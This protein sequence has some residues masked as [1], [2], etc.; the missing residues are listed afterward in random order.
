MFETVARSF[1]WLWSGSIELHQYSSSVYV[2][3]GLIV[4]VYTGHAK[5]STGRALSRMGLNV[6][7]VDASGF[8]LQVSTLS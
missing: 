8:V 1:D 4:L 2:R 7:G 6:N 3:F 5:A